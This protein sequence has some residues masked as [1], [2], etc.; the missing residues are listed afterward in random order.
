MYPKANLTV[1]NVTSIQIILSNLK[2]GKFDI[3]SLQETQLLPFL[4]F[5]SHLFSILTI[6][7]IS[8][9]YI[10]ILQ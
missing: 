1:N 6:N 3:F 4:E 5:S 10:A 7:D 9:S 2:A 8:S